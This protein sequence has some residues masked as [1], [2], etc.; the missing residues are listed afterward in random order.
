MISIERA[1]SRD[2]TYVAAHMRDADRRE[3]YCQRA[4]ENAHA[5]A[6]TM[7]YTSPVHCYVAFEDGSP[8]AAFGAGELHPNMWTAWA[9]GTRRI[10]RA[11]PAVS[12][13]IRDHMI[14]AILKAGAHRC[15]VRS[16][17]DHDIAHRWLEGLGAV[18]EAGLP[19]YGRN[20]E[21]FILFAWRRGQFT[22][23]VAAGPSS[24]RQCPRAPNSRSAT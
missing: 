1:C 2:V 20:G 19:G 15:E 3:I 17:V 21:D 5:M 12:R 7:V 14:P 22:G 8:V 23:P 10:R 18:R 4:D 24:E 11:I 9:F 13:H 16:I 6:V